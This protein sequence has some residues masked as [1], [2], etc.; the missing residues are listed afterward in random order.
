MV[1]K[2]CPFKQQIEHNLYYYI[3][4][5]RQCKFICNL[6]TAFT[7]TFPILVTAISA[8]GIIEPIGCK[9]FITIFTAVSS[10]SAGMLGAFRIIYRSNSEK[11]K[12]AFMPP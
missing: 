9:V 3:Y 2:T 10:I 4:K 1:L 7:V 8:M 6:L 5:A 11:L 12:M